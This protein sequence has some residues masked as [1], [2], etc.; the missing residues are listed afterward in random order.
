MAER[1]EAAARIEELEEEL[2]EQVEW[3][4]SLAYDLIAAE[5]REAR[6]KEKLEKAV[7]A[8]KYALQGAE[9]SYYGINFEENYA[10]ELATLAE[11]EGET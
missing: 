2:E 1:K 4:R 3:V 7:D 8:L 11:L 9:W 5:G 6:L 10:E